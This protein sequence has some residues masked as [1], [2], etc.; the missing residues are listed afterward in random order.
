M[1]YID[2][3]D[4]ILTRHCDGNEVQVFQSNEELKR[5][6]LQNNLVLLD[7]NV[8]HLGTDLN[9]TTMLNIIEYLKEQ[10]E[11]MTALI[12][13]FLPLVDE[14][15]SEVL[16]GHRFLDWPN[17]SYEEG[18]HAGLQGILK[19]VLEKSADMLR[20]FGEDALADECAA[21]AALNNK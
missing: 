14:N 20:V 17:E 15:G 12:K 4:R 10:K 6:C 21:Q 9:F 3:V 11:Y 7:M 5:K 1:H 13:R 18:K 16:T 19:I 2:E 8:K